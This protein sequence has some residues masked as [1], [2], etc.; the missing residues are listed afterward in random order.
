MEGNST[1]TPSTD[2][3]SNSP[4]QQ[5]VNFEK[6]RL[7][8]RNVLIMKSFTS[9][10][11]PFS[12]QLSR[13]PSVI[14]TSGRSLSEEGRKGSLDHVGDVIEKRI[15]VAAGDMFGGSVAS[16]AK[17]DGGELEGELMDLSLKAEPTV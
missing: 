6:F 8:T 10:A 13:L 12:R 14:P 1:F 2:I 16:I 5:L 3:H 4:T 17:S 15:L 7:L 9:E 11:Y